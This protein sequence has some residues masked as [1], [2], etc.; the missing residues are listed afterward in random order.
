MGF[1][2]F[3][4][5]GYRSLWGDAQWISV[6]DGVTVVLGANNSGKSNVLRL[7]HDHLADL[8]NAA[9]RNNAKLS[10]FD[11]RE[12]HPRA[13]DSRKVEIHWPIDAAAASKAN[14]RVEKLLEL[15]IV[16]RHPVA[17][18]PLFAD[19][20][21]RPLGVP[22]P[23]ATSIL[24]DHKHIAWRELSSQ[25]TGSS[26]GGKGADVVR[27]FNW[28]RQFCLDAPQS[29]FVPPSRRL[30]S[31]E[32]TDDWDFGG[33]GVIDRL[34][35]ILNPEFDED[36]LRRQAQSLQQDLRR[37]LEDDDL[38]FE[39]PHDKSTVN[40]K[41]GGNFFPLRALG[42]G[43]EHAVLILAAHHVYPDRLLCLE[44]PDAHLHPRLQRRLMALM[45]ERSA[46][47]IVVA[48]HSAHLIDA[49]VDRV[50]TVRLHDGRSNLDAV[51]DRSLFDE[52]RALGYRASDI[53][54][55]NAVVWVE[56]PSDRI[57]LLHWLRAVDPTLIEGVDFS[58]A[59]Y[60]G[61]L[62]NR[63]SGD[64]EGP[65]DPTLVDLWRIN[66]RMWLVMDSDQGEGELKPAV[67]RLRAEI[68]NDGRGGTWIT[69][70]YTIEN[71]IEPSALL[72]A[73]RKV[74][75]SVDR[76][77]SPAKNRDPLARLER[78]NRSVLQSPDK[79]A[80]AMAATEASAS[81]DVFDLR[82]RISE[83]AR[84]LRGASEDPS[85]ALSRTSV[86]AE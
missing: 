69:D 22:D 85:G 86:D 61:A 33:E 50:V 72:D 62:L 36:H 79:V 14:T 20:L 15:E 21:D 4:I 48:T 13:T 73:V 83:L 16:Q 9:K 35:R 26:G 42:T 82:D 19:D 11:P 18:V 29:A 28:L 31:K 59:F 58:I 10:S 17:T 56:G 64:P 54:Q 78:R 6:A 40:V 75:P 41:L 71:Y 47:Q 49:N 52:L 27:V 53:L 43:T 67:Q 77:R 68:T 46:R 12:D 30:S 24:D 7:L 5:S 74:H 39:V 25:L 76:I 66:Q 80:I 55:A 51:T 84:F 38:E 23:W 1:P 70:G 32:S 8:A 44:E 2:G 60:G 34:H 3:A 37:L 63:I 45:R 57:Y 65:S 81:L